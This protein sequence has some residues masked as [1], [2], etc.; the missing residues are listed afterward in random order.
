MTVKEAVDLIGGGS[1]YEIRGA[2][3]G[4]IYHRSYNNGGSNLAKYS[5]NDVADTPF[6]TTLRLRGDDVSN[7]W[8]IPVIG[9]WMKDY[10]IVRQKDEE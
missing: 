2:Y 10:D 5:E 9:I 7:G 4:R 6:Y 8:C 3:S 1:A